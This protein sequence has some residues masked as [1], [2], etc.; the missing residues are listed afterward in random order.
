[1]EWLILALPILFP[2]FAVWATQVEQD[3]RWGPGQTWD[4]VARRAQA[5]A[6]KNRQRD[7]GWDLERRPVCSHGAMLIK[8][9]PKWEKV[10]DGTA[11]WRVQFSCRFGVCAMRAQGAFEGYVIEAPARRVAHGEVG[12]CTCAATCKKGCPCK[13]NG[14]VCTPLCHP[15]SKKCSNKPAS[16]TV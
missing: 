13:S 1:M 3:L 5:N 7:K 12:A 4:W 2:F 15:K 10:G 9:T 16:A 14:S 11:G 6:D 8:T